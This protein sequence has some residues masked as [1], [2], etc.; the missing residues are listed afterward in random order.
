M[1]GPATPFSQQLHAEKY[2]G[3]GESFDDFTVRFARA[4]NDGESHFRALL[5]ALRDQRLLP[6]GRMQLAVGRPHRITAANCYVGDAIDDSM[7]GIFKA[8][9]AGALTLRTGGGVGWDFSTLRPA[10]DPIRGLGF[11][12][13]S[14]GPVSFMAVWDAM[15]RTILSAGRRRGAM[16]G[17]LR[18]DHPDI[19]AFIKAKQDQT[20]LTMFNVSVAVT[21]AF[22]EALANGDE[23]GLT[24][25]GASYGRADARQVFSTIMENNW[26]WAEPGIIFIDHINR[27]NPLGYCETIAAT[28]PCVTGDTWVAT[29]EGPRQVSELIGRSFTAVV[30]GRPWDSGEAG[31]FSTGHKAVVHLKTQEGHRLRLTSDHLVTRIVERTRWRKE[32]EWTRAGDLRPGDE[33]IL[34]DHREAGKWS[35]PLTEDEGYLIGLLIGDGTLKSDKAVLSIWPGQIAVGGEVPRPGAFGIMERALDA[36]MTLPH[37]SDFKGWFE[38]TGRGEYRLVLNAV[39]KVALEL[40]MA[41]GQ[42]SITPKLEKTSSAF[43]RGFLRGFFDTDG[44]IQGT[45]AKGV[46][47]RIGQSDLD[48][49]KA[50]Q[51]ML[52]RLGIVSVIYSERRLAGYV[53][54]PDGKG[55]F[56]SYFCKS[57]HELIISSENIGRFAELIGF[58]DTDKQARLNTLISSYKRKFNRERFFARISSVVKEGVKDVYDVQIPGINAFDANGFLVHNCSEQ[59]LPPNGACLLGS[60]NMVK[61]LTPRYGALAAVAEDEHGSLTL[62]PGAFEID[63]DRFRAD[64]ETA[65][66]AFDRVID[67]TFYPLEE[68]KIEAHA[69]RRMGLGVT[70]VAN[71]LEVCGHP[72]ASEPY[73]EQQDRILENLR[74]I[75]Y[76]VSVD[77]A[78]SRGAFPAFQSEGWL[79]SGFAE[80]LPESLRQNIAKHGL[81]NGLLLS[82]APTGTISLT[83]DNVSSGIEP[84]FA[85]EERR[86]VATEDGPQEVE[87]TDWAWRVHNVR[88]RT[89]RDVAASEHIDVLCRTQAYI[90]SAVSKTC[91]VNGVKISTG[92]GDGVSFEEFKRL[93]VKAYEGGAKG[94]ATFNINGKRAGMRT[95]ADE[96]EAQPEAGA[97]F[98]NAATGERACET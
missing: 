81:R 14:S 48:R 91:N 22:M 78:K 3:P 34:N 15:C 29:V 25:N 95:A 90:D 93:Y 30:N 42:K 7:K 27:M 32:T 39:K 66:R 69:K 20:S 58:S 12:A 44:S 61:Y 6:A 50:V 79:A 10:G 37:R 96:P 60:L 64:I 57:I 45:Q 56:K 21:D 76:E 94:C 87:L 92:A 16:M 11:R 62:A 51:R 53:M 70:G 33:V 75:A 89:A 52:L 74:D 43:Y 17:I 36:A 5:D 71:A 2:R 26:D 19:L 67:T 23:Y 35:G 63:F 65:V 86:T 1:I 83:A 72:Y 77:L 18:V 40:G 47:I 24:F 59:P 82:I 13:Y 9:T 88:G 8:L 46:S 68:Q 84:P 49:L 85:L 73:L 98:T 38:V 31:F 80:T 41:P 54:L 4:A 55:S 97:C 28:N